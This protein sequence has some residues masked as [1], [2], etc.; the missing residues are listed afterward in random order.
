MIIYIIYKED[1]NNNKE[2][3][4]CKSSS[5]NNIITA[6]Q[7]IPEETNLQSR[8]LPFTNLSNI[9]ISSSPKKRSFN[10]KFCTTI[11]K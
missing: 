2:S 9:N 5:S 7:P 1:L 10:T 11:I 8:S 3:Y 6:T 4:L